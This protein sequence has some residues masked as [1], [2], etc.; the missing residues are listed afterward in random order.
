MAIAIQ[1]IGKR[2]VIEAY[3]NL[4]VDV[5]AIFQYKSLM[6]KGTGDA[7][8]EQFL[9]M[10]SVNAA[11]AI[12]TLKVYEDLD[13]PKQVK[14]KTEASAS[15]NF[16]LS[17][18]DF[19]EDGSPVYMNRMENQ[20]LYNEI[21][22]LKKQIEEMGTYKEPETLEQAA[23][24]LLGNP[25]ELATLVMAV[26]ELFRPAQAQAPALQYQQPASVGTI[27]S[28]VKVEQLTENDRQRLANA[29]DIL[30]QKDAKI[31][32]HLEKLA[33]LAKNNPSQFQLLLMT[34]DN[35]K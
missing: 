22:G 9:E 11:G 6:T 19:A 24:G 23:I 35:M 1:L 32:E 25:G 12:Y 20:R 10:L 26:K 29:L 30:G 2:Q 17:N 3:R 4:D 5:W 7:M 28:A 8:L 31:I 14:E 34:L 15:L 13:D 21:Q 27:H 16:K 18:Q 33:N